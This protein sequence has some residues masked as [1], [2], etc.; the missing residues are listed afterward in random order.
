MRASSIL[1]VALGLSLATMSLGLAG[2]AMAQRVPPPTNGGGG[3]DNGPNT[4]P[5]VCVATCP[6]N[7]RVAASSPT[8]NNCAD[9][10]LDLPKIT[11]R[12]VLAVGE[13]Q[14]LHI[15]PLCDFANHSLT[16]A[17]VKSLGQGNVLGLRSYIEANPLIMSE[18]ADHGYR[19]IDLVGLLIGS[20]AAVLYVHK[21]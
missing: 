3:G 18:L 17:Q 14:R 5:L 1:V 2:A 15:A 16:D 19:S 7:E 21:M 13:D 8:Q 20:N 12:Q 4:T 10:L 6:P 11:G 9:R